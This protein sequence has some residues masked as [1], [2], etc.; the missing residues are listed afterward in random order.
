MCS[1]Y[2]LH[3]QQQTLEQ[4][5][6]IPFKDTSFH[7]RYNI[8]PFQKV[9]CIRDGNSA[10]LEYLTWGIKME[11]SGG[12]VINARSETVASKPLFSTAFRT[13]RCLIIADGF[14][15]W[16]HIGK[17]KTPSYI[18]LKSDIPFAFAGI[19]GSWNATDTCVILTVP[20]NTSIHPIHSRMPAILPPGDYESWLHTD[21]LS[22]DT[23]ISLLKPFPDS[24]LTIHRVS[25]M[26]NSV[27]NDNPE[28]IKEQ[29]YQEPFQQS[30][31]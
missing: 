5:F 27:S 1:R 21:S 9:L 10:T 13:Q 26:V 4:Y 2:S 23:A 3:T 30:L 16:Q 24:S 20:S 12:G 18:K 14:Y 28:C 22:T 8:A 11:G 25:T 19:S 6:K 15:E 7:P 31:L 29:L 17:H